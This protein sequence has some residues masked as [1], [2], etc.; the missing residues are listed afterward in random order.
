MRKLV[1]QFGLELS[2]LR[3]LREQA[4]G[5]VYRNGK[6]ESYD[7]V[8]GRA[9]KGAEA[10]YD[11]LSELAA[12]IDPADPTAGAES[13][14]LDAKSVAD[15]IDELGLDGDA[16]FMLTAAIRDD[17]AAE[18]DD[19]SLLYVVQQTALSDDQPED[20]TE[21]FR[22]S[23]GNDQLPKALAE[24]LGDAVRLSAPVS[25]IERRSDGV[26]VTHADGSVDADYA[27]VAAP[28]RAL[29]AIEFSPALSATMGAATDRV[30]YGVATKVLQQYGYRFWRE[31]EDE[32]GDTLVDLDYNVTWQATDDQD[33]T[34]GILTYY[35]AGANGARFT[36]LSDRRRI[37]T[38]ITELDDLYDASSDEAGDVATVAW[39][40]Q[41]Y[42]RGTWVAWAPGQMTSFYDVIA[43]PQGTVFFAGEHTEAYSGYMESAVRSGWRVAREIRADWES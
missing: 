27:I 2:D 29:G 30:Q 12:E 43:E 13:K 39:Q 21:A 18:P 25:A 1:D 19:L 40:R 20:G 16:R 7:A 17:Y 32:S 31:D 5:V 33:G 11:S 35:T 10:F 41:R 23:G 3:P 26:T 4:D 37:D 15:L 9:Q 6:R 42:T 36:E 14:R 8:Y 28:L 22:I 24:Q 38:A 34:P